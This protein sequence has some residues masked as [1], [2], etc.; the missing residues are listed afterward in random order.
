M[1]IAIMRNLLSRTPAFEEGNGTFFVDLRSMD[2]MDDVTHLNF[3][4]TYFRENHVRSIEAGKLITIYKH[5]LA[6]LTDLFRAVPTANTV[7]I[8][9]HDDQTFYKSY[10]KK[11]LVLIYVV[12]SLVW[13]DYKAVYLQS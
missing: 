4:D 1:F 11:I 5:V 10:P 3:L 2:I 6:W 9:H 7:I 8:I 13:N 12:S